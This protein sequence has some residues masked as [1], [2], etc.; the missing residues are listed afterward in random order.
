M[1]KIKALLQFVI[2]PWYKARDLVVKYPNAALF[3][4]IAALV[5]NFRG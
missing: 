3:A 4:L 2:K 1:D 5:A